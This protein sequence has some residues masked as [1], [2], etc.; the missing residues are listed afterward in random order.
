[1]SWRRLGGRKKGEPAGKAY[2]AKARFGYISAVRRR[3]DVLEQ[4]LQDG[5]REGPALRRAQ[6]HTA[7]G[8]RES[9]CA[10]QG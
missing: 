5:T 10:P 7:R 4:K 8:E 3:R 6:E 1:M 9:Q 2:L